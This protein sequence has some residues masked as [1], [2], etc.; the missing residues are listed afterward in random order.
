L[1]ASWWL[2]APVQQYLHLQLKAD[3]NSHEIER[4]KRALEA[5]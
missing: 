2:S 4:V 1:S 5:R 3:H